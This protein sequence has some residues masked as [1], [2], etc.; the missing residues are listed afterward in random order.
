V[1]KKVTHRFKPRSR[2]TNRSSWVRLQLVG[3][4]LLVAAAATFG[5]VEVASAAPTNGS[6]VLGAA[7]AVTPFTPATPFSSG[8]NINVVVPAN[9]IFSANTNV[10]IVECAA[11][12]GVVPTDPAACDGN[13][14]NGP[15]LKPN[16]DGSIN[17]QTKTSTLY[18]VFALP[19]AN[20]GETAG[21][22]TCDLAHSCVLYIGDD[23]GD[24]TQPHV[25]SQ[26]FFV[27]PN[28]TD[29]GVNPGDG[30]APVAATMPSPT[31][32]S[33]V[34][35]PAT[36]AADGKDVSTVTVTLLAAGPLPVAART[37]SLTQGSGHSVIT[38]ATAVTDANGQATFT[39][40]DATAEPVTY[41]ATDTTDNVAVSQTAVVTYA[42][43][44]VTDAHSSVVANPTAVATGPS[45][46]STITVTLR[47]QAASS[48][49]IANKIVTLSGTGSAVIVPGA[50]PNVTNSLGVATFTVTDT[51]AETATFTATDTSDGLVL[52]SKAS[53]TFGTLAV[54]STQS[55]VTAPAF[56]PLGLG[57]T[58]AVVTLLTSTD[59]PVPAK[60]V[61]LAA[62]SST[63]SVGPAAATNSSG[64][65]TFTVTDTVAETVTLTATDS[66]DTVVLAQQPQVDFQQS[67]P[68]ATSSTISPATAASPADGQT[69]TLITVVIKDQFGT[70][71]PG[72]TVQLAAIPGGSVQF[73]PIAVGSAS[74]GVT[75]AT[76]TAEFEADDTVAEAVTFI[77][78]DTTDSFQVSGN[79]AI[80]FTAGAADANL[81]TVTTNPTSVPSDGTTAST[82]TV[83]I[84]DHFGNHIAGKAVTVKALNG[85][86]VLTTIAGTTSQSGQATF[87][88]TDATAEVVTYS[89]TD[90]T[91]SLPLTGQGVITFGSPPAPPPVPADSSVVANPTSDPADGST[92]AMITVLLYDG[93]GQPVPG[94][95]VT[96]SA[97]GG[98]SKVTAVSGT[99]GN[100]GSATFSVS[101]AT[102]ESVTYTATD[103]TDK[104]VLTGV[105][106]VVTF[107][108]VTGSTNT[109]TT[110][111]S[112]G[113]ASVTSNGGTASDSSGGSGGTS[114]SGGSGSS[115][116]VTGA[117][118]FLPWLIGLGLL[119]MCIGTIGRRLFTKGQA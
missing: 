111:S 85:S 59:S 94:K 109:A 117:P 32:S 82:I 28:A 116:A 19:D 98:S 35:S 89:A 11:P 114:S 99:S 67:A 34:A 20:L 43:P 58:T 18:Q 108:A 56:A 23:Q 6:T 102:P 97:S 81:S 78:T 42:A 72:K 101:D 69:Q 86:S 5:L 47:D 113:G 92:P 46:P 103:T 14:I 119:F 115:L 73:R 17:F 4:V 68:S 45:T 88:A 36:A 10:N 84:N 24:F 63:A 75:D 65:A 2:F 8:Q 27:T 52:T 77:A 80:T 91:D 49:P 83:T 60:M 55:T 110:P 15:T 70:P 26:A 13:T 3:V 96:L 25:W 61:S 39:V 1:K 64:Q 76:G 38:P 90:S 93:N 16:T 57:G 9:S 12:G 87:T 50:T 112:G 54:S 95:V 40:T 104:V 62:S 71:L 44:V 37:V 31:L 29:S 118:A 30:S 66:T 106:A 21:G 22:V 105:T 51:M 53:V 74:P 33:V 79:V 48:Q 100:T 7:A 107:T 41:S